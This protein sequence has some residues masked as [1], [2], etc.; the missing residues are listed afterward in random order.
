MGGGALVGKIGRKAPVEAIK[1]VVK[2][3][4]TQPA[5]VTGMSES[6]RHGE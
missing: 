5:V 1:S 2:G 6:Q 4:N 3:G